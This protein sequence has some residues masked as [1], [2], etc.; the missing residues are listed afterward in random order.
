LLVAR[1]LEPI[2]DNASALRAFAIVNDACPGA[3]L[4]IAGSGSQL[5]ALQQLAQQLG[6]AA[7]VQFTGRVDNAEMAK[8]YRHCD[9]VLNPS[10]VDNMP[11]SILE[12]LACAIPVVSTSVGG[13]PVLLQHEVTGLLVAPG[14][15]QAM[16]QA[17]LSLLQAPARARR[18]GAAGCAFVQQFAWDQVAPRLL[19]QYRRALTASAQE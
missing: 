15:P 3:R 16:A 12:A 17:A 8:L 1:N 6:I 19:A 5:S 9:V 14:D 2:Y 7:S 13:I 10:L 11:I 18:I 4:V